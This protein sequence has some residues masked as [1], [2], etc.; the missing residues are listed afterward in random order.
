MPVT[1]SNVTNAL[2]KVLLPYVQD[3]F[4]KSTILLDQ[5]KRNTN[6]TFLNNTFYAPIRSTRHGGV[7]NLTNDGS[8]LVSSKASLTQASVNTKIVTGTFDITK[9]TIEAT[10]TTK[11]AVENMLTFQAKTLAS[12]FARSVNR[13]FFS[14]GV[15]VVGMVAGSTSA[16][17]ITVK[18]PDSTLDDTSSLDWY[19]AVNGD[20][21]AV[22]YISP[23]NI[24]AIGSPQTTIGTVQAVSAAAGTGAGTVTMTG[25]GASAAGSAIYLIDGG[26][27][28]GG[29]VEIQGIRNALS[30][31]TG[32]TTYA[33]VARNAAIVWA[34]Q[35][36]S[37]AESLTMN[38]IE[39]SYLSAREY[40][41]VGDKYAIF[42]NKTLYNKYADLLTAMRRTIDTTELISGW[43]GLEFAA[44]AGKVGVFLDYDV[45]DGEVEIIDFDTW[46]IAQVNDLQWL[47]D[48][49]SGTGNLFRTVN[50][51]SYQAAMVWFAN[52]ICVAP[53]ANGRETQKTK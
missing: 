49:S 39:N 50:T 3:N 44:G 6:T 24:I 19:G 53:A 4:P 16:T 32:A 29:T 43:T 48:P 37:V 17:A 20:I 10:K 26:G 31:S 12:D 5:M 8:T 38:R 28:N 45:P 25:G 42:V 52:L 46:T 22:K 33:G 9:L 23:G 18:T 41:Q 30:S 14:D 2:Q 47:E 1:L 21:N 15:G 13:Q 36:G 40:G 7:V 34:P 51:I 27:A 35:F 11:G